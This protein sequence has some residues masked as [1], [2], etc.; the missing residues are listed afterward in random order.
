MSNPND[1][2]QC[3]GWT[4]AAC[5]PRGLGEQADPEADE[6]S[7]L[8]DRVRHLERVVMRAKDDAEN[9][10]AMGAAAER[11]GC[12]VLVEN[13]AIVSPLTNTGDAEIRAQFSAA[14]R[15]RGGQP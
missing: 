1:C 5:T 3:G 2:I 10:A 9:F 12:A 8:R 6:L 14:I 11:E 15:A 13:I 4:C 7:R